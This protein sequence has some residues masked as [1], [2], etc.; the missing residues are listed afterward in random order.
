MIIIVDETESQSDQFA[1]SFTKEGVPTTVFSPCDFG[2]WVSGADDLDVGAVDAVLLGRCDGLQELA[3]VVK[4]RSAA[5]VIA[6][7]NGR[8]LDQTLD[9]FAAGVDDV[10]D[11]RCHAREILARVGAIM[12]RAAGDDV[13]S[14]GAIQVFRD[15]REPIVGGEV[16]TLPRRELRILEYL[17]SN[18]GRR[19]SKA[20][21][22]SSVYGLFESDIDENVIESHV[23]KLRKRLRQR[24]GFDPIE[25]RR[26]LGYLLRTS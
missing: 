25:S 3:K 2:G 16:M 12:R 21:I 9:L 1:D 24:L 15:G 4:K 13:V 14:C 5:A 11:H 20:Q 7:S 26:H 8:S 17:V 23:S 10:V 19:V 6:M 18:A 22:F